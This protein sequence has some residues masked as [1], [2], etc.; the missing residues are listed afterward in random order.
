MSLGVREH[1]IPVRVSRMNRYEARSRRRQLIGLSVVIVVVIAGGAWFATSR[2]SAPRA[3]VVAAPGAPATVVDSRLPG[4]Y[5]QLT[6]P[7]NSRV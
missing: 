3:P 4:S 1:P 2:T 6:L 5:T 7:T